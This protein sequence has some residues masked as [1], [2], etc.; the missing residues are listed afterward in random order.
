MQ[1]DPQP[2]PWPCVVML[3]GLLLFCLTVPCYWSDD[4]PDNALNA[5]TGEAVSS[6]PS[7]P[8]RNWS[9]TD[10]PSP[11]QGIGQNAVG[12]PALP[13]TGLLSLT[14]RP[15]IEELIENGRLGSLPFDASMMGRSAGLPGWPAVSSP[16]IP[17]IAPWP[18]TNSPVAAPSRPESHPVVTAAMQRVGRALAVYSFAEYV[19]QMVSG[20]TRLYQAWTT[21]RTAFREPPRSAST[22]RLIG[23][24]DRVAMRPSPAE[25]LPAEPPPSFESAN[26][27][28]P[29]AVSSDPWC[30]P[31]SLF[32]QLERLSRH[33]YS[34]TWAQ[35]TLE[36]LRSITQLDV[37]DGTHV[38][39]LLLD[40]SRAAQQA[41]RMAE[42]TGDDRLR[43]ELLRAHWALAR[44]LDCWS[45]IH[46]IR[47]AEKTGARIASRGSLNSL[48]HDH[49]Q[50]IV[51]R[52]DGPLTS[53]LE[54]YEESRD[55]ELGRRVAQQKQTLEA[56]PDSLDQSLA[57]AVEQHYRNANVRV[58]VT[59]DLI[60]RMLGEPRSE[61]RPVRDRIAGTPVR[62]SSH[63]I[64]ESRV[65][66]E[67]ARGHWQIDLQAQGVVQSDTLADGG[68]ARLRSFGATD[69]NA[70]KTIIVHSQGVHVAET[71]VAAMNHNRLAGVTTDFDWVPLFGSYAR[72]RAVSEYRARRPRAKAEVEFKV[73]A[74]ARQQI[75]RQT[76][77]AVDQVERD[78]RGRF[79]D[80]LA[81]FGIELAPIELI[82]THERIVARL[83]VAGNQQLGG[84]TPRPRA[85][86][87]SLA[88]VQVHE[89]ALTNA[90]VSLG[91]DGGRFT[92]PELQAMLREK[93]PRL[94]LENPPQARPD[95]AFNFAYRDAV[96][97][98]IGQGR[99]EL[100]LSLDSLEHDGRETRDFIVHAFYVPVVNGLDAELVRDGGLGI[101][102]RLS[103]TE[104][105]RLHNVFNTVL[106]DERRLPILRLEGPGDARLDGLMI[107][108]LV[109]EDGWVGLAVGPSNR[110][111][112]AERSRSLR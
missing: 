103:S 102:G 95:T 99:L 37:L 66:L 58:A 94:A 53:D 45:L 26:E 32:E 90:A 47:I 104:R 68:R 28:P 71:S 7:V 72:S 42:E 17:S 10:L 38:P 89:T 29:A 48:F 77:E 31:Q 100:L 93:F 15:T 67:P 13:P 88:S 79:L 59:D 85:L 60:N 108:Q 57:E 33:P 9:P 111:R 51:P 75:D 63:T 96:Q 22:L 34:A 52:G 49:E 43:V 86:S 74:Q 78:V 5:D 80:P 91:L 92:A 1:V 41:A 107:T 36:Q 82:T 81:H 4:S 84:H 44:R 56:S 112:V 2:S 76:L 55:A 24:G 109:L 83:R 110:D 21:E 6:T 40:L 65:S 18:L 62:G 87:D 98:R 54:Q 101:E 35:T 73:A 27:A 23:P 14:R 16:L 97:F 8:F 105:A 12:L 69:F 3:V 30:V 39:V 19:P 20:A 46:D 106:S 61:M 11:L 64:S 70:R 25:T 50:P